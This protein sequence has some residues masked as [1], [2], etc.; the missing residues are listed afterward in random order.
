MMIDDNIDKQQYNM[1]K[2]ILS[3]ADLNKKEIIDLI[4]SAQKLKKNP[5]KYYSALHRKVLLTFFQLPSLRTEISFDVGM[6]TLG[7]EIVDYHSETS[8][9]AKGKE[10][11]EDVGRVISRYVDAV[12]VRMHDHSE[13]LKLAKNSTVPIINGL[14]SQEHPC[15]ILSDLLTIKER[16]KNLEGLKLAY[17]GDS[18]NNVTHSLLLAC[19]IM[20][21]SISI[22]CP[23]KKE[24]MPSPD[25]VRMAN[26]LAQKYSLVKNK[27]QADKKT[28]ITIEITNDPKIAAKNADIIYTDSWMS[29]RISESEKPKR[30]KDLDKFRV[31]SDIMKI[32][33]K[34]AVFM[35]D[36]P[37]LRGMEVAA[38]VMDGK[39]SI[40]F[41]QAENRLHMQK[42][43]LVELLSGR[44]ARG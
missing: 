4:S 30:M 16:F 5:K 33:N 24:Y 44:G 26:R 29:Y 23:A 14:T 17:F 35:H 37:G 8:P 21:M 31:T 34:K 27:K 3:I 2:H 41:D 22:A 7:G 43:I 28:K 15:Q 20:G 18:L 42:A 1:K 39:Q 40:I 19:A 9:W 13:L 12:M 32:A 10:S 36:L 38:E 6:F 25:V 11:I